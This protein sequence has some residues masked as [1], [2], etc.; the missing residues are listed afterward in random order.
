MKRIEQTALDEKVKNE[1]L[2]WFLE[3]KLTAKGKPIAVPNITNRT[4]AETIK[5]IGIKKMLNILRITES[6]E[7]IEFNI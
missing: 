3:I 6:I 5:I 1:W 7:K 4:T 2:F